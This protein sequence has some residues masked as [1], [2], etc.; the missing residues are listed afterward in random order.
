MHSTSLFTTVINRMILLL[1][2]LLMNGCG[3]FLTKSDY[4]LLPN[5]GVPECPPEKAMVVFLFVETYDFDV[6]LVV[7]R[8]GA[9]FGALH[10]GSYFYDI[11][12]PGKYDFW[13]DSGLIEKSRERVSVVAKPGKTYF[14]RYTP[15]GYYVVAKLD[16][17]SED[18]ATAYLGTLD[19]VQA[20]NMNSG[21]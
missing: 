3:Q 20:K 9:A 17:I 1:I 13:V 7:Y 4:T 19:Y 8:N 5:Q 18:A 11:V 6:T 16:F 2:V 10:A 12:D 15:G 21:R 14:A